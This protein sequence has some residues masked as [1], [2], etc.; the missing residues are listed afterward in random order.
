MVGAEFEAEARVAAKEQVA[1]GVVALSLTAVGASPLPNWEPGAHVDLVLPEAATRQYSLC[2]DPEDRSS[3]RLGIL[4]DP[5][6]RGSSCYVHDRLTVG[7]VVRIRGPRNNFPLVASRR[8]LFV[9]GGIGI[10]RLLR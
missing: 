5:A 1:E 6:G 8:Y 9:A 7:D 2:G 4:R 3:Y 10:T